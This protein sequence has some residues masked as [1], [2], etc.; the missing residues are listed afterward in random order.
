MIYK[1]VVGRLN[2]ELADQRPRRTGR[3]HAQIENIET[4]D[5]LKLS[6]NE[7]YGLQYE[8]GRALRALEGQQA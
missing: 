8:I 7:L 5:K 4:G 2:I 3:P 6:I 1:R